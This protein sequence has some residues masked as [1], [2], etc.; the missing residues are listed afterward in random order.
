MVTL[1][2]AGGWVGV[3]APIT[4]TFLIVKVSGIPLIEKRMA[5]RP[6]FEDYKRRTSVLIPLLPK[7]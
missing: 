1:G 7:N 4:I 3:V 6:D 5:G 2:C